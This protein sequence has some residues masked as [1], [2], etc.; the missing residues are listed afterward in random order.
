MFSHRRI[1][2]GDRD[3]RTYRFSSA[4]FG[5]GASD[6][7]TAYQGHRSVDVGRFD[8]GDLLG[9]D[10]LF[11]GPRHVLPEPSF[12]AEDGLLGG[13]DRFS[14]RGPPQVS[15]VEPAF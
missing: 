3:L 9:A 12:P 8:S 14:L 11:D 5:D 7:G 2:D 10:D 4:E 6:P 15:L 13:G 1:C